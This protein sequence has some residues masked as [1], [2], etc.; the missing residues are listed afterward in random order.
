MSQ[1][2]YTDL[3]LANLKKHL[4]PCVGIALTLVENAPNSHDF[5]LLLDNFRGLER[6]IDAF[7]KKH[8]GELP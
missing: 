8:E 6:Q 1:A 2:T 7:H 5:K 3:R 4:E